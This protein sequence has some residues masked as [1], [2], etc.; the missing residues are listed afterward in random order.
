MTSAFRLQSDRPFDEFIAHT[1]LDQH[2]E[3]GAGYSILAIGVSGTKEPSKKG[4][5]W[6]AGISSTLSLASR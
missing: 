6:L 2:T 1:R 3:S 5:E 4:L